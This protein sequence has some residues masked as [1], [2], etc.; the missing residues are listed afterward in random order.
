MSLIDRAEEGL[1]DIADSVNISNIIK[2]NDTSPFDSDPYT[3]NWELDDEIKKK[4]SLDTSS[5][6]Q[7]LFEGITSNST[8]RAWD[9]II[10]IP[11]ICFLAFLILRLKKSR[12]KLSS[13]NNP[14]L[15]ALYGL[16]LI[17]SFASVGR[18]LMSIMI[19]L[20]SQ[21]QIEEKTDKLLWLVLR[22]ILFT[23]E[24]CVMAFGI[25]SGHL[26]EARASVKRIV[27][28]SFIGSLA[29][30]IIK[31]CLEMQ[32]VR[33]DSAEHL[34][35]YYQVFNLKQKYPQFTNF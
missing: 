14:V 27:F 35:F 23:T 6:K 25:L 5:C 29:F 19:S 24:V 10:L 16:V 33:S 31:A 15:A 22:M 20:V 7:I 30:S 18:C 17:C 3:D 21:A 11:N 26:V 34:A 2:G 1:L 8:V 12:E 13:V 4:A 9:I 32:T 28:I